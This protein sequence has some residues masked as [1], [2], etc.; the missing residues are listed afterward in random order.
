MDAI[1]CPFVYSTGKRCT[2][3]IVRIEAYKA[4]VTWC[5]R[6]GGAWEFSFAPRSHYHLFCSAKGNHA[7]PL[8]R[9]DVQMKFH[10]RELHDAVQRL[11]AMT[12]VE[13]TRAPVTVAS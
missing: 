9:D 10:W 4:D 12:D 7:G 8:R 13:P 5:Q 11:I 2:G 1:P 3:H 6:N